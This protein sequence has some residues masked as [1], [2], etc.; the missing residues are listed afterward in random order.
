MCRFFRITQNV[1]WILD[2]ARAPLVEYTH[3]LYRNRR[4]QMIEGHITEDKFSKL[5]G[6]QETLRVKKNRILEIYKMFAAVSVDVYNRLNEAFAAT[7]D[8]NRPQVFGEFYTSMMAVRKY[9]EGALRSVY[10]DYSDLS[11]RFLDEE[12]QMVDIPT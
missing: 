1:N 8:S 11:F 6:I 5:I 7:T 9:A 2:W 10:E 4:I 3:T 12:F